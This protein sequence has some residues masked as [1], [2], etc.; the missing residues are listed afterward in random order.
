MRLEKEWHWYVEASSGLFILSM[1]KILYSFPRAN[2]DRTTTSSCRR[3][4]LEPWFDEGYLCS[5]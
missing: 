5:A 2:A 4:I 3:N 1:S